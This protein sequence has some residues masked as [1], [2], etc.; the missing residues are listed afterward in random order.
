VT[1]G[2][3]NITKGLAIN[4]LAQESPDPRLTDLI[5]KAYNSTIRNVIGG[6]NDYRYHEI[7]QQYE[8][9][10]DGRKYSLKDLA[11]TNKSLER[12][13]QIIIIQSGLYIYRDQIPI[14]G[15]DIAVM[16]N[17]NARWSI[18]KGIVQELIIFKYWANYREYAEWPDLV[19]FMPSEVHSEQCSIS[20]R[21]GDTWAFPYDLRIFA[22]QETLTMLK[23]LCHLDE[24]TIRVVAV[25]PPFHGL[26]MYEIGR[27]TI[28]GKD[29][30][31]LDETRLKAHVGK[32]EVARTI[33]FLERCLDV[34]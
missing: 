19:T 12:F 2:R 30:S 18:D 25:C 21:F 17:M 29:V 5:R 20:L 10:S 14:P 33:G 7:S 4:W 15:L 27:T 32:E 9:L 16:G 23:A 22:N 3:G 34:S 31:V 8:C 28:E 11:H 24:V 13:Q 6:H 26:T 1:D